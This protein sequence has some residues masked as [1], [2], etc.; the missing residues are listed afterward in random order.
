MSA[1]YIYTRPGCSS[2]GADSLTLSLSHARARAPSLSLG[3]D[4]SESGAERAHI[5]SARAHSL[6]AAAQRKYRIYL[7]RIHS[8]NDQTSKSVPEQH[9]YALSFVFPR[10]P[11]T[12]H[13]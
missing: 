13:G 6:S 11:T 7:H 5:E 8:E 4:E 3:P 10:F 9:F 12:G 2:N 1:S